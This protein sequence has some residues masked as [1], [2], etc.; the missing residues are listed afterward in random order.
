VTSTHSRRHWIPVSNTSPHSRPGVVLRPADRSPVGERIVLTTYASAQLELVVLSTTG[1]RLIGHL[2]NPSERLKTPLGSTTLESHGR[3]SAG[4][5]PVWC[6]SQAGGDCES[7]NPLH[8]LAGNYQSDYQANVSTVGQTRTRSP[9]GTLDQ[10]GNVV[11]WTDTEAA[12]PQGSGDPRVWRYAHGGV[13]NAPEYQLWIS[14]T[15]R[16]PE[17]NLGFERTYPWQ[18]FRIGVIGKLKHGHG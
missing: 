17:A 4:T 8:A 13:A 11:E 16:Q 3:N 5:Y 18:G 2:S 12:S 6:P 1:M 15:G 7:A 10:G 9:W 14:V